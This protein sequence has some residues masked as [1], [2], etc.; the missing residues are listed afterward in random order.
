MI[1]ENKDQPA[2][3]VTDFGG[4]DV[5]EYLGMSKREVMAMAAMQAWIAHHGTAGGYG[6]NDIEMA[7]S[8]V[9][10]ADALLKELSK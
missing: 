2:H 6:Y 7:E 4:D 10:S 8:A 9:L 5:A 1:T 3:P